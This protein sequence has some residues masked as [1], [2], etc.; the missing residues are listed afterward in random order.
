MAFGLELLKLQY[1][2]NLPRKQH[3]KH[4]SS[5]LTIDEQ[6]YCSILTTI[7]LFLE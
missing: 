4:K 5:Y 1:Q 3:Q 7:P 6:R 2:N